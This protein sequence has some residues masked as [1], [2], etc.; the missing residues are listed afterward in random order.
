MT[1]SEYK[2]W[3][4]SVPDPDSPEDRVS[5]NPLPYRAIVDRI[6][7]YN[8]RGV[9][10]FSINDLAIANQSEVFSVHL[11][12]LA[13]GLTKTTR[14]QKVKVM[15]RYPQEEV[16]RRKFMPTFFRILESLH[17]PFEFDVSAM[18]VMLNNDTRCQVL[19]R[20]YSDETAEYGFHGIIVDLEKLF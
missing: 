4:S 18:R 14:N 11:V 5:R 17:V 12:L 6:P 8:E 13:C 7:R 1:V 20:R 19:F 16:F 9:P 10:V 3:K 15:L 2:A